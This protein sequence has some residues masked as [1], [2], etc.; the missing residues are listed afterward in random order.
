MEVVGYDIDG[1]GTDG[2]KTAVPWSNLQDS[3]TVGVTLWKRELGG[4]QGDAQCPD[5]IS[6]ENGTTYHRDDSKMWGRRR[7][8]VSSS[9][10]GDRLSGDP[11]YRIIDTGTAENH[12]GESGLPA[13][14][15]TVH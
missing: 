14:V 11:L 8:V 13:C 6:P 12:S 5:G 10:G 1:P 9:R 4:D 3:S 2:I 7:I 15:C